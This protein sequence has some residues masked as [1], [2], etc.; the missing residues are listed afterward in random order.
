MTWNIECQKG[1]ALP[2]SWPPKLK[3]PPPISK[4]GKGLNSSESLNSTPVGQMPTPFYNFIQ[5]PTL[6][7][8]LSPYPASPSVPVLAPTST[9]VPN[10]HPNT[11]IQSKTFEPLASSPVR[12]TDENADDLLLE[13]IAWFREKNKRIEQHIT[14]AHIALERGL[15]DLEAVRKMP[16]A[17]WERMGIA[18]GL[19]IRLSRYV[20]EFWKEKMAV[21]ASADILLAVSE[22]F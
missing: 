10:Q 18:E 20:K 13:Y 5:Y 6:V 8:G 7:P 17:S 2:T 15:Y 21:K 14:A 16:L 11:P 4:K 3:L 9:P 22:N 19:G 12:D 1:D